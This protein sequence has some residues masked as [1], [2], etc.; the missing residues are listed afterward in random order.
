MSTPTQGGSYVRRK[1][2]TLERVA[3][4]EAQSQEP[5]PPM[6][7]VSTTPPAEPAATD[8]GPKPKLKD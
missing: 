1:D 7:P 3:F 6:P 5:A 2:G 4:T 8:P